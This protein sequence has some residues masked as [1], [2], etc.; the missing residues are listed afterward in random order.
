MGTMTGI[1]LISK[2]EKTAG[3]SG[4]KYAVA[5]PCAATLATPGHQMEAAT[6]TTTMAFVESN[7][8][9]M[10]EVVSESQSKH[11]RL[12]DDSNEDMNIELD[13]FSIEN[14]D[15]QEKEAGEHEEATGTVRR[16]STSTAGSSSCSPEKPA[17]STLA[18]L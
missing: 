11:H 10:L 3:A 8:Q 7:P 16:R 4:V 2:H 18:S 17:K 13:E 5:M 14:F 12:E 1:Y 6:T 9:P 15:D